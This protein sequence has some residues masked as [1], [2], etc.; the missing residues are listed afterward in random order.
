MKNFSKFLVS[1]IGGAGLMMPYRL[2]LAWVRYITKDIGPDTQVIIV[3]SALAKVTRMLQDI[4]KKKLNGEI[5]QALQ[6]FELIKKIHLQRC[7]DLLIKDPTFLSEYFHNIEYFIREG[8]INE[9]N[10][11]ISNAYI[12]KFGELMSSAI[13]NQFLLGKNLSIK[14]ID[15]QE[16]IFAS[17]EDYC[18]SIPLLPQTSEHIAK[19]IGSA[20]EYPIIL[21]QGYICH[22][23][24][25]GLD[26]SDLT[27]SLIAYALK[28][29]Y[30]NCCIILTF[31]KDILGVMVN[32]VVKKK[33][34]GGEY[35]S[36]PTVP[37]RKDAIVTSVSNQ[38][39]TWIRSFENLEH[40]GTKITQ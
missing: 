37:V 12:L 33:M 11:T 18:N 27:A 20:S 9:D 6:V 21:T 17:G 38:I 22:E 30:Q 7:K 24:L 16:M 1:K 2:L 29:C 35:N 5:V 28:L 31:W 25:L 14:L 4:F 26:G 32:G 19:V 15:A 10:Q 8:S 3:V 34:K 40:E 13:I 39:E 36:L 23:R